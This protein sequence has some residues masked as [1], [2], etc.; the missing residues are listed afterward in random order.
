MKTT[1][2]ATSQLILQGINC[3]STA[4]YSWLVMGISMAIS[5]MNN[6]S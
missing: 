1:I 4:K 5:D 6:V 2:K 3:R